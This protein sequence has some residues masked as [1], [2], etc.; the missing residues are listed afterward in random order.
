MLGPDEPSAPR[1]A[2]HHTEGRNGQDWA[3]LPALACHVPAGG[4]WSLL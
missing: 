3:L 1:L 4:R 2:I